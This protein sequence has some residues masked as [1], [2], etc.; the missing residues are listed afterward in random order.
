MSS[1]P[2]LVPAVAVVAFL[3]SACSAAATPVPSAA[4]GSVASAPAGTTPAS[5]ATSAAPSSAATAKPAA[6]TPAKPI[7]DLTFTGTRNFTWKGAIGSCQKSLGGG[8]GYDWGVTTADAKEAEQGLSLITVNGKADFKWVLSNGSG[9][10]GR[11][12]EGGTW[13]VSADGKTY[14]VDSALAEFIPQSGPPPGAQQM[15]GTVTCS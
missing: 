8:A 15:K 1:V 5:A 11:P 10:Y 4:P 3:L 6:A 14:T 12:R 2:R 13:T 9:G 7:V